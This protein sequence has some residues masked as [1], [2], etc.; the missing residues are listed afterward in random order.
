M[1]ALNR[2]VPSTTVAVF[3]MIR[4]LPLWTRR[5]IGHSPRKWL[6][7]ITDSI[8]HVKTGISHHPRPVALN[9]TMVGSRS[10]LH[11]RITRTTGVP[12]GLSRGFVLTAAL[13]FAISLQT[14]PVVQADPMPSTAAV[15]P[16]LIAPL[17]KQAPGLKPEVLKLALNAMSSAAKRGLV[18]R[19]DL[20]T[21]IDYSL[22]STQPRLFTFDLTSQHL[23]FL[24]LVAHGK[25]SGANTTAHF[26]ND[27]G[28]EQ[29]SLGLFVTGDTY[30]GANGLSMRLRGLEAGFNDS[31]W[32]RM[33]VMHGASY[34]NELTTRVLG[35]LGRSWG[36]PA[37]RREIAPKMIHTLKNGTVIFAYYP[38][39]HWLKRSVF[40]N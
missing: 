13:A 28:S 19:Q 18:S 24:E 12:A 26:S 6:C 10:S 40:L 2:S 31:A 21:V 3:R 23:V 8:P 17:L 4:F 14:A 35:R 7:G 9:Q 1:A 32:A 5:I 36:C 25:N 11:R 27:L 29:S 37:V 33:I 38:D 20:L 30:F 15:S 39:P 22:P 16:S 34:V